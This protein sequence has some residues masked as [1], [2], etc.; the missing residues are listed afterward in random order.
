MIGVIFSALTLRIQ[1]PIWAVLAAFLVASGA[2][3]V[4]VHRAVVGVRQEQELVASKARVQALSDINREVARRTGELEK[5]NADFESATTSAEDELEKANAEIADLL[6][7]PV[8]SDC[9][10][11]DDLLG[12]LRN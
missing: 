10:V 8:P 7:R 1:I 12:R 11:D 3:A 2:S 6:S 5:A 9:R 4:A